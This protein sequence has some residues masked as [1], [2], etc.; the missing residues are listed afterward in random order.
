MIYIDIHVDYIYIHMS[1]SMS[2]VQIFYQLVTPTTQISPIWCVNVPWGLKVRFVKYKLYIYFF[3]CIMAH[4]KK[5]HCLDISKYS[6][7][8]CVSIFNGE[9]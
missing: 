6:I 9:A 4:T 5:H 8:K 2:I 3:I 1:H 7:L